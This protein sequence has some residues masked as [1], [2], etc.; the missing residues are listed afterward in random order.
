MAI[1][2]PEWDFSKKE[3]KILWGIRAYLAGMMSERSP[4]GM[5]SRIAPRANSRLGSEKSNL[6]EGSAKQILISGDSTHASWRP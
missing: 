6:S 2:L 5:N 4:A 3:K 1:W